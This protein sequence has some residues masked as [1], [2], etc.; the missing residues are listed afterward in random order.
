[1]KAL[2]LRERTKLPNKA[3]SREGEDADEPR[4]L[5]RQY[6]VEAFIQEI[7]TMPSTGIQAKNPQSPKCSTR[8]DIYAKKFSAILHVGSVG[9][10]R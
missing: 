1:M 4:Q 2:V 9:R 3:I 5:L 6:V 7:R 10:R 8:R